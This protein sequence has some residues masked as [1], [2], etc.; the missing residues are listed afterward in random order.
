MRP[1][2][3]MDS[4]GARTGQKSS[5]RPARLPRTPSERTGALGKMTNYQQASPNAPTQRGHSC[6]P[7]QLYLR[8]ALSKPDRNVRAPSATIRSVL[9]LNDRRDPVF[10]HLPS[11]LINTCTLVRWALLQ[12][13]PGCFP[14]SGE[15][16]L[17]PKLVRSL[18]GLSSP[19]V[20]RKPF[21]S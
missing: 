12:P 9:S 6:P 7:V 18:T 21:R 15:A 16:S 11:Y 4:Q 19:K 3:G 14:I 13:G 5:L 1:G 20:D 17:R 2:R 10:A 8:V